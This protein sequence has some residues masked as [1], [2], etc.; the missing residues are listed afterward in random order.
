PTFDARKN[1]KTPCD[2]AEFLRAILESEPVEVFVVVPLTIKFRVL[3]YH[4]L[5]RGCI[6]STPAHPREV[7]KIAL[8]ANSACVLL[9][10]NHPSGDPSP[11]MDDVDLTARLL[12]AG[13]LLGIEVV[14]HVIIG[15]DDRYYSFKEGGRI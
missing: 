3:G 15:H 12:Q 13:K 4:E 10:H 7:F 1:L 2:A 5:S 14:D 9:G 6:D 8:L 11:S